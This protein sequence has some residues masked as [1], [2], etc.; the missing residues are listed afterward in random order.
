MIEELNVARGD[1]DVLRRRGERSV[2]LS[3]MRARRKPRLY[4]VE[5]SNLVYSVRL[6]KKM[7]EILPIFPI[8]TI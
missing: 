5:P 6:S 2:P 3:Y 4:I 8:K 7:T 1:F